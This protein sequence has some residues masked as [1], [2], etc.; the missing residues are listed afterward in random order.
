MN[1]AA[2]SPEDSNLDPF[3]TIVALGFSLSVDAT[4]DQII[5]D[6]I[7][8]IRDNAHEF[9]D[10]YNSVAQLRESFVGTRIDDVL[11]RFSPVA[12]AAHRL[13]RESAQDY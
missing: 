9:L 5:E 6:Q 3:L 2:P 13:I 11:R 4:A 12:E 8:T 7:E 10:F 1:T